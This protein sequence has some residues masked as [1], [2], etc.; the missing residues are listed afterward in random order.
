MIV[1]NGRIIYAELKSERGKVS[2][3]QAEWL[4][5]LSAAG[6]LAFV[7]YPADWLN[8]TIEKVLR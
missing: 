6:A 4:R 2:A 1:G 3:V 7:W 5:A 8:G